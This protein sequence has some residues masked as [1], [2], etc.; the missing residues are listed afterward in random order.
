MK[1]FRLSLIGFALLTLCL[2]VS[3]KDAAEFGRAKKFF[4]GAA[5]KIKSKF[6]SV[7]GTKATFYGECK[8][9][10]RSTL[11]AIMS[12]GRCRKDTQ[13]I[14]AGSGCKGKCACDLTGLNECKCRGLY[15]GDMTDRAIKLFH[16]KNVGLG[17][18]LNGFVAGMTKGNKGSSDFANEFKTEKCRSEISRLENG[19]KFD[20]KV[21]NYY[22]RKT[23]T[24]AE[25]RPNDETAFLKSLKK[26]HVV[27][28]EPNFSKVQRRFKR[29]VQAVLNLLQKG[30]VVAS[31][32]G[33][34]EKSIKLLGITSSALIL[35]E[36]HMEKNFKNEATVGDIAKVT[37]NVLEYIQES[38]EELHN[39]LTKEVFFKLLGNTVRHLVAGTRSTVADSENLFKKFGFPKVSQNI[40]EKDVEAFVS[41]EGP[42]PTFES[43]RDSFEVDKTKYY[44]PPL[45]LKAALIG[46]SAW[47]GVKNWANFFREAL[48]Q[49]S[50]FKPGTEQ[51]PFKNRAFNPAK[52]IT[53]VDPACI[54]DN[55]AEEKDNKAS[56]QAND[57]QSLRRRSSTSLFLETSSLSV[58]GNCNGV[59]GS[60]VLGEFA[61]E[62][63]KSSYDFDVQSNP[64][65]IDCLLFVAES[66][67][68][69]LFKRSDGAS[70]KLKP[71]DDTVGYSLECGGSRRRLLQVGG[72][73]G[74]C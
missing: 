36:S 54:Q 55:N 69:V 7:F 67:T 64:A 30:L 46:K 25:N 47:I 18:S 4:K 24:D 40:L 8:L 49:K 50:R 53:C 34:E 60:T 19:I 16:D 27:G 41:L 48:G 73:E 35:K 61:G 66:K 39:D 6:K 9:A 28:L 29:L 33:V 71:G 42:L 23:L 72:Q 37:R 58:E 65:L 12:L 1:R 10:K 20:M 11:S 2:L 45:W 62:E 43:S 14:P 5:K 3:A 32:C 63:C 17:E 52:D 26:F 22:F 57:E 59:D 74:S 70:L 13:C 51:H 15:G 56:L 31:K 68:E 44:R 38:A 21:I